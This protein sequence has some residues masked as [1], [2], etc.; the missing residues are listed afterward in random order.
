MDSLLSITDIKDDVS[1]I[2]DLACKIKAGEM[3]EKP[4]EGKTLAMIFQKV[5]WKSNLFIFKRSPNG[6]GR[7][8]L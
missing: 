3:E 7:A 5:R 6:K 4:L 8:Y 2:L 1:Y